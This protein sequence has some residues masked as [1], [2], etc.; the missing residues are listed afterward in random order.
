VKATL[1]NTATGVTCELGAV[2][3]IGRS[4]DSQVILAEEEVSRRHAMIRFQD[5]GFYLFDLG[6]HNGTYL[7]GTRVTT[8]RPLKSGDSIRFAQNDF[9]F[10][11]TAAPRPVIDL[12]EPGGSTIALI[13]SSQVIVLVS[14]VMGFTALSEAL[15]PDDLARLI[16]RWYGE[17]ER[18]LSE[19]GATIDK[20]IGDS[21]L[22]YWTK[23]DDTSLQ[24]AV[25]AARR[26]LA[27]CESAGEERREILESSGRRFKVG[28]ALHTGKAAYGGMSEGECTLVGDAVNL[29]FRIEALTRSLGCN[30]LLSDDFVESFPIARDWCRHLGVHN[31]KGR[32][33]SVEIFGVEHFPV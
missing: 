28:V 4:P 19:E 17:C 12:D 11:T 8:S 31:V 9:E 32:A 18:I 10:T 2:S 29:T 26:L 22:A 1:T 23:V 27:N 30:C 16:G 6:S 24:S 21:V 15:P 3:I 14:D 25:R 13:R 33:Q 7:N 5:G 20:F